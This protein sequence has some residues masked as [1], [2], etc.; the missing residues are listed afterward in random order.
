MCE[1]VGVSAADRGNDDDDEGSASRR[2]HD[3]SEAP[4]LK[5]L[6]LCCPL[7]SSGGKMQRGAAVTDQ[8]EVLLRL[9]RYQLQNPEIRTRTEQNL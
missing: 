1:W 8:Q 9:T 3:A 2:G 5:P 4:Q 6:Q 7:F